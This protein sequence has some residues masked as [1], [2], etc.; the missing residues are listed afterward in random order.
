MEK[1]CKNSIAQKY[2]NS[3]GG[4]L[5]KMVSIITPCYN[6][7]EYIEETI[8]SIRAQTY[9][10]WEMIIIDDGSDDANTLEVLEKIQHEKD[11]RLLRTQRLRPAGAR[12]VGISVANGEYI[13]P[14][15]ADDLIEPTYLER[16]VEIMEAN[17]QLG[18][19][20]CHADLFGE[21][22]GPWELP[23]Y[24]L[25]AML[26]DNVIF[27]TALFRRS[28]WELI[29]GF[30]TSMKHGME[31]YDFWL[32]IL[33]LGK[34]AYQLPETLFHY[35]IKVSSR[36]T[37]FQQNAETVKATYRAIYSQ[38]PALYE[39]YKDRYAIVLRDALI[40][41]IFLNRAYAE[42]VGIIEKMKRIPLLKWIIKK[43]IL[44]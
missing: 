19:V 5:L 25:D 9:T 6:D 4:K 43:I 2:M 20:Y 10:N 14:V 29:G 36:T 8:K 15:D 32:S 22:N 3:W 13:L 38:H 1:H 34:E 28:D 17:P 35:R 26:L 12:N 27:V 41:H 39:K 37:Q 7:G 31:D 44:R 11:I 33:E 30:R 18:I 40:E 23:D 16:A 24:T 21:K 42:S